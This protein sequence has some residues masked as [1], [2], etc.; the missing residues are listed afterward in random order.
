M[1]CIASRYRNLRSVCVLAPSFLLQ[2][3]AD[4]W[5]P[6][7][8]RCH[9]LKMTEPSSLWS[10]N[11]NEYKSGTF[12]LTSDYSVYY[13]LNFV[14]TVRCIGSQY[15]QMLSGIAVASTLAQAPA[16]TSR[17]WELS[18]SILKAETTGESLFG[19]SKS[20]PTL[21]A[22]I[23]LSQSQTLT[24]P[25]PVLFPAAKKACSFSLSSRRR[26]HLGRDR[27]SSE[28]SVV[29]QMTSWRNLNTS[30]FKGTLSQKDPDGT[31]SREKAICPVGHTNWQCRRGVVLINVRVLRCIFKVLEFPQ[32]TMSST[33]TKI[34][35]LFF[36]C[37]SFN[38]N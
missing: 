35:L 33:L 17:K 7:D 22:V 6:G 15:S 13:L 1:V 23:Q 12:F 30:A 24:L 5:L 14:R 25:S 9:V 16:N 20:H 37:S 27:L 32:L 21:P 29:S 8:F 4:V 28:L 19:R 2:G 36:S 26:E 34:F 31:S 11:D 10:L 18:L 3:R 38:N